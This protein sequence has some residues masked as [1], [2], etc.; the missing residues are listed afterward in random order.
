MGASGVDHSLHREQFMQRPETEPPRQVEGPQG[1][2]SGW[3][4]EWRGEMQ[5][6]GR[7]EARV[8]GILWGVMGSWPSTQCEMES[9][10]RA[11]SR[12]GTWPDLD[13]SR[14]LGLHETREEKTRI[15]QAN[16]HRMLCLDWGA[17][18]GGGE[19]GQVTTPRTGG[20]EARGENMLLRSPLSLQRKD[21]P[22][23]PQAHP[24]HL[25]G[26]KCVSITNHRQRGKITRLAS[27]TAQEHS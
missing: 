21:F 18:S 14:T 4:S 8:S 11:P 22:R 5:R 1:D 27:I 26:Q 12:G 23:I 10:W 6:R 17:G 25:V 9:P 19:E 13:S 16:E 20:D 24:L 15:F 3:D 2:Q 7:G